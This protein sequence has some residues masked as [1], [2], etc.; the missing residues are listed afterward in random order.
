MKTSAAHQNCP[1]RHWFIAPIALAVVVALTGIALKMRSQPFEVVTSIITPNVKPGGLLEVRRELRW[2]RTDC[3]GYTTQAWIVDSLGFTH[4][5]AQRKRDSAADLAKVQRELRIP[6][7]M[8]WGEAKYDA[9]ISVH[10]RPFYS[11]WPIKVELPDLK[12]HVS[13]P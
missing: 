3:S 2:H 9:E 11:A 13:P 1:L 5:P 6:Y 10:C 8:S 12:F 7:T 4:S